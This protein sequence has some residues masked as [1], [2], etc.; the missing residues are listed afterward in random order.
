MKPT[1]VLVAED[2]PTTRATLKA[3]LQRASDLD[4]VGEAEDG[5]GVLAKAGELNPD[6]ILM[7]VGLPGIDGVEATKRL[8]SQNAKLRIIMV[9]ANDSDAVVFDAFSAGADGYYLKTATTDSLIQAVRTVVSGAA[10]LHPGIASRVLRSCVRGATKL[11]DDKR[12]SVQK[13]SKYPAVNK[14]VAMARKFEE[15]ED[16]DE[17][18]VLFEGAIALCEKLGGA[19]DPEV[20][21]L[22]TMYADLLYNQ[23][24]FVPSER[25]YLRALELRHQALGYEHADV[26]Q[27]LENLAH[28]Y[29]TRSDYAE[30]EHYYYWSLKIRE[31]VDGPD[32]PL[33]NETCAKLAWIY[34][35]QG[36]IELANQMAERAA[37]SK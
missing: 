8:K 18:E 17:A 16:F 37:K 35:A 14:L 21:G 19:H 4:V 5:P 24:K 27:S 32:N 12:G 28:L 9:T 1:R 34:R 36:K 15:S 3:V 20:A 22:V 29:D 31:K 6:V 2:S 30:A 7:D 25:L 23:E 33:T 10:W 11:V 26:A 13:L